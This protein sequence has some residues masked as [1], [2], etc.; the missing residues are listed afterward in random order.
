MPHRNAAIGVPASGV[1]PKSHFPSH[2]EEKI[3]PNGAKMVQAVHHDTSPPLRGLTAKPVARLQQ[4]AP[5]NPAPPI[6][7]DNL[8]LTDSVV[9]RYFGPM[10]MPTPI[11]TFDGTDQSTSFCACLPPDT[12]GDVGPNHYVQWNNSSIVMFTKTGTPVFGPV[13]GNTLFAGFP[14]RCQTENDGDPIVLYDQLAGRWFLSQF[15][16]SSPYG[17]CIAVSQT[18]DPTGSYHRYEYHFSETD[19]Y[20]YE[21]Y[22]VWPDGYYMSANV[23]EGDGGFHP[24]AMVYDRARMLEGLSASYVEFNP[25]DYFGSLLP[26]DLDGHT[27]PP[28]G[29]PNYFVSTSGSSTDLY[30]WKFFTDFS[31]PS[32]FRLEGPT[33]LPVAPLDPNLCGGSRNCIPQRGTTARLDALGNRVMYRLAYRNMGTYESLLTNQS[34]DENGA[35]HAGV[36]WYEIRSPRDNP[37]IY[38]QGTYAP[39][40]NHRWMGSMAMD[41]L[42][43]IALG[44]S[45]SSSAEFP[46]I[47]YTGRSANDPLGEMSRGEATLYA[48]AGSQTNSSGRW[49]DYSMMSVDPVDDCTFWYTN[50]YYSAT[51]NVALWRT[52]I[53]SFKFES[54]TA[55]TATP[56]ATGTPPTSTPTIP[57]T[58]TPS[59]QPTLCSNYTVVKGTATIEPGGTDVGNHCDDCTTYITLPFGVQLYDQTFNNAYVS[60]NGTM[61]FVSSNSAYGNDCLPV[62]IFSYAVM[63]YWDD[64]Y[65]A[66]I[67]G[68]QGIFMSVTGTEPSRVLNLEWRAD[69]CCGTSITRRFEVRFYEG[70][71]RVDMVYGPVPDNGTGQTVGIQRDMGNRTQYSCNTADLSQ[72]LLL[73]YTEGTCSSVGT[74]SSTATTVAT[75]TG[76]PVATQTGTRVASATNVATQT[77]TPVAAATSTATACPVRFADVQPG[78]TFYEFTRCLAC[79][80]IV[81]G[82]PCGA[83]GEPCNQGRDAYYRPGAN[84]TRG[85]LSKIIAN[86]AGLNSDVVQDQQQFAD[87]SP[88]SPFYVFVERLAQTGA[89]GGYL[90][91]APGGP[92]PCDEEGRPY[93]RP[94]SPATRGQISKI[95]SI[96]AE[97]EEAI[98]ADRQTFTDTPTNSP[99]WLYIERLTA[100]GIIS[101][102]GKEERCPETGAPCFRYSDQTTRGQ[103]AKIA[104]NSF[105]PN[106]QTPVRR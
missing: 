49:G 35:D 37:V 15:L 51:T 60:S 2:R 101:G 85:Q 40:A 71:N 27:P 65:T 30:L 59:P 38:Q 50:E 82:Y 99:F 41:R 94:N 3:L 72:N 56:T 7:A 64:L 28:P 95:V 76:T 29:S 91:G 26:A 77:G 80:Q 58:N 16:A 32:A 47:R 73:I 84:V 78:D 9:Q 68:G 105:F 44:Y 39:D 21:K 69:V 106:C 87:V 36:R 97:F 63:P 13:A 24:S 75:Q 4:E 62:P 57:P 74:P 12:N 89:I 53:G 1:P 48:G 6:K 88:D 17:M 92:E 104:A 46:S 66:D 55:A 33:I 42:G 22:G 96:A 81:S 23:F 100:R 52:R 25:G 8:S 98:P 34:V 102:Y 90:C 86:S 11:L 79:R 5:E 93:F 10:I 103:M 43:N 70:S 19:F 31:N 18:S 83:A 67:A 45:V 20:D 14:G 61:Q 54:C